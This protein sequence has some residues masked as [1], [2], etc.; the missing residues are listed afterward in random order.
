MYLASASSLGARFPPS[1]SS[2][3]SLSDLESSG[4]LRAFRSSHESRRRKRHQKRT[5]SASWNPIVPKRAQTQTPQQPQTAPVA[6]AAAAAAS[7]PLT[8][9]ASASTSPRQKR[10]SEAALEELPPPPP[11]KKAPTPG[12]LRRALRYSSLL[13]G[14]R[15]PPSVKNQLAVVGMKKALLVGRLRQRQNGSRRG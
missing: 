1:S 6:A 11:N 9:S 10:L 3:S 8:S 5:R 4:D 2:S 15:Q 13:L 12:R 14:L 7:S